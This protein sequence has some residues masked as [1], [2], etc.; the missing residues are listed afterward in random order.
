MKKIINGKRYNFVISF[1]KCEDTFCFYI[2]AIDLQNKTHS[3]INNLNCI[4]SEFV[5][6]IDDEKVS[7]SQ[8][9]VKKSEGKYIFNKAVKFILDKRFRE[10][11]E[12]QLNIDQEI[13]DWNK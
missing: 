1:F 7:E 2:E 3:F 11:L 4:L 9:E 10:Y 8:W 12:K 5:I 6:E 13:G